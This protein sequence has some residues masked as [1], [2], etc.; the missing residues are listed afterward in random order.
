M[1]QAWA[2]GLWSRCFDTKKQFATEG[3]RTR[4]LTEQEATERLK[5]AIT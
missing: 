2:A 3:T 1:E 4:S 5:R